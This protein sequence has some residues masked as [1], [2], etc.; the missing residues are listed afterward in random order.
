MKI[1]SRR[2]PGEVLVIASKVKAYLQSKGM[3]SSSDVPEALTLEVQKLLDRA[4]E[5]AKEH[6]KLTVGARDI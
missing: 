5:R 1:K 6:K 2:N 4:V 3:R